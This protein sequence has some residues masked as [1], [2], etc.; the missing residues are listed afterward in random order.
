MPES[1]PNPIRVLVV[2]DSALVRRAVTDLLS[3]DPAIQ[4]VGTAA[5]AFAARAK[6][7][8]LHPH[9]LT[10]DIEMPGMDGLTFLRRLMQYRPMPVVVMSSLTTENS[11]KALEALQAGAVEVVD[12]PDGSMSTHEDDRLIEKVKAA[13]AARLRFR[14]PSPSATAPGSV[15]TP[16]S[17]AAKDRPLVLPRTFCRE[18]ILLGA[19][20]GGTEALR[21]VLTALP[22]GLP[23]ILIVQHIPAQFSRAFA[24]RLNQLCPFHVAEARAGERVERGTAL[25]APGGMHLTVRQDGDRYTALLNNGPMVHHQRPSVDVLFDS[26]VKAQL[27]PHVLAVLMTGMGADG[28]AGLLSLRR[29]GATTAAQDEESCV[30]FGMPREAIRLGAAQTVLPLGQIPRFIIHH[31]ERQRPGPITGAINR[32]GPTGLAMRSAAQGG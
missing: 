3:R 7:E 15:P 29:A 25:V 14:A 30:V 27:A 10:L 32:T 4:V 24:D 19:S 9:V 31:F 23:G 18:L 22:D 1:T 2:D 13:A 12:K 20:T 28:A 6:L 5:D 17:L 11:A 26:A 21:A 8:T 16:A